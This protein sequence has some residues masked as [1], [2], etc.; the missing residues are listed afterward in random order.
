[1]QRWTSRT[2]QTARRAQT[3]TFSLRS[4]TTVQDVDECNRCEV[5][6]FTHRPT[7]RLLNAAVLI[8]AEEPVRNP[9]LKKNGCHPERGRSPRRDVPVAVDITTADPSTRCA[10][11]EDGK[12][13]VYP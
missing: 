5:A 1:M 7:V 9:C 4:R 3:R 11:V 10:G 2:R 13:I 6:G 8:E 12:W